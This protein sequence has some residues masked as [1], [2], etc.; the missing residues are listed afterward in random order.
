MTQAIPHA[1][2]AIR[3]ALRFPEVQAR[4]GL[5]RTHIYRLIQK[6]EFPAPHRLSA[7]VSAWDAAAVDSWLDEKFSANGR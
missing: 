1:A 2:N 6:N 3:K 5:S 4:T 7:R